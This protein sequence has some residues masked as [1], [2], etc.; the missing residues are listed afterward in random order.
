MAIKI[1]LIGPEGRMGKAI[2]ALHP[3]IPI[4]KHTPRSP[5][6]CDILIDV[7]SHKALL[8][9]LSAGKPIV[10]GT[11][12]HLN[13]API[14]EAAKHLPIFYSAN[15]TLGAAILNETAKLVA[16]YFAGDIDLIETHH[17]AKKDAPSGTALHLSKNLQNAKI[18]S[19]RSG[20]TIG[21]HTIIFNNAEEK[22]TLSHQVHS[23]EAF[24]KGALAAARFLLGKPPGLYG[25]EHLFK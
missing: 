14:Q 18:H 21:E 19:L 7:S 11:T 16:K 13:F 3:V 24:A 15:F 20:S 8:E 12:G 25:M 10:I 9:N 5:L 1:G 23:R 22:L 6:D 2:S 17:T 4:F